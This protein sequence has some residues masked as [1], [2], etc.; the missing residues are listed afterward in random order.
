MNTHLLTS[1]TRTYAGTSPYTSNHA[2]CKNKF[3]PYS[4]GAL[5]KAKAK[6]YIRASA[7]LQNKYITR[8]PPCLTETD[9]IPRIHTRI[10]RSKSYTYSMPC[11]TIYT[12]TSTSTSTYVSP[13]TLPAC[14]NVL[15]HVP[16][17]LPESS[18][19][20]SRIGP[21]S[22]ASPEPPERCLPH[23]LRRLRS[24]HSL[25]SLRMS[26]F[27]TLSRPPISGS[28]SSLSPNNSPSSSCT[29]A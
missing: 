24:P 7:E 23:K 8:H 14:N 2:S 19:S 21:S 26:L 4:P 9:P 5:L 6:E 1:W 27:Y 22:P 12:S 28:S 18:K 11:Q 16:G 13:N 25:R 3:Y 29:A 15:L 17:A 20:C 10:M